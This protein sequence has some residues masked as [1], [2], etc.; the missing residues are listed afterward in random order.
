MSK[1]N[2]IDLYFLHTALLAGLLVVLKM[3]DVILYQCD[4]RLRHHPSQTLMEMDGAGPDD[5]WT[6]GPMD[7]WMDG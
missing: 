3:G 4:A 6:D 5:G 7:G 2:T 1:C